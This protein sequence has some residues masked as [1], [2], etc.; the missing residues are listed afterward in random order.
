MMSFGAAMLLVAGGIVAGVLG[1]AGGITS[2]VSY[3]VLLVVGVP[4]FAA[5]VANLVA[6]VACWPASAAVSRRELTG[7]GRWLLR[8]LPVAALGGAVGSVLLLTTPAA[9][10]ADVVPGLVA[11]GS[12][13]LLGQPYLTARVGAGTAKRRTGVL[14]LVLGLSV[15]GGYFG[16]GSGV[17]LLVTALVLITS[18]LPVANAVKNMLVGADVLAS[19]VVLVLAGPVQWSAVLFLGCGLFLGS[20]CGP[21]LAR[22]LP[23]RVI[24]WGV[25]L[26]GLGLAAKLGIDAL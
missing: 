19:A 2:L 8:G 1:T 5:N 17:M 10:F 9:A 24:R 16:A 23:A 18:N 20:L 22:R 12:L 13:A 14:F 15:Y 6:L 25:G 7:Q 4:P 26:L 3:P 11:L 21:L